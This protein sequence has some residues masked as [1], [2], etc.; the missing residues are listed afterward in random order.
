MG[1]DH[2]QRNCNIEDSHKRNNLFRDSCDLFSAA[3]DADEEQ[4]CKHTADDPFC[5]VFILGVCRNDTEC[6]CDIEGCNQIEA[7]H[8]GQ[9]HKH[10]EQD[11]EP[12]FSGCL[13]NV[14]GRTAVAA[15]VIGTALVDLSQSSLYERGRHA[16]KRCEPHPE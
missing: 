1:H 8:V 13:I 3:A 4:H 10:R 11:S 7:D 14:V 5:K 9:D 2:K 6:I 12:V 16:Q 15:A